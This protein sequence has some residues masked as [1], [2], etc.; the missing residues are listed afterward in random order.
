M[1]AEAKRLIREAIGKPH[2]ETIHCLLCGAGF[3][4]AHYEMNCPHCGVL[5]VY[6]EDY[7]LMPTPREARIWHKASQDDKAEA[8]EMNRKFRRNPKEFG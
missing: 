7:A 8:D 4:I 3:E 1:T 5:Y 2:T 6:T